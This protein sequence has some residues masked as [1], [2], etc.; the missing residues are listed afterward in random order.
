MFGFRAIGKV[1]LCR[2]GKVLLRLFGRAGGGGGGE[3]PGGPSESAGTGLSDGPSPRAAAVPPEEAQQ[4]GDARSNQQPRADSLGSLEEQLRQV[5]APESVARTGNWQHWASSLAERIVE[6][7]TP[8]L[9]CGSPGHLLR[10]W[11]P[12]PMLYAAT[13]ALLLLLGWGTWLL[14]PPGGSAPGPQN[15]VTEELRPQPTGGNANGRGVLAGRKT[16]RSRAETPRWETRQIALPPQQPRVPWAVVVTGLGREEA[17]AQAGP[18]RTTWPLSPRQ[19]AIVRLRPWTSTRAWWQAKRHWPPGEQTAPLDFLTATIARPAAGLGSA[20]VPWE[21]A[22]WHNRPR[23]WAEVAPDPLDPQTRWLLVLVQAPAPA[24]Q[25]DRAQDLI[26]VVAPSDQFRNSYGFFALGEELTHLAS[27]LRPADRL[28]VLGNGG[29]LHFR[30]QGRPDRDALE[31]TWQRVQSQ[32]PAQLRQSL[33][34]AASVAHRWTRADVEARRH[35]NL[36]V[37]TDLPWWTATAPEALRWARHWGQAIRRV[38]S[39]ALL[40]PEGEVVPG[41]GWPLVAGVWR[42]RH[43]RWQ[44][45]EQLR[46]VFWE[47]SGGGFGRPVRM[48]L[49]VGWCGQQV[50]WFRLPS[51]SKQPGGTRQ[52]SA[53]ADLTGT[54]APGGLVA[55]ML[56]FAPRQGG[57]GPLLANPRSQTLVG[58]L[59]VHWQTESQGW[60]RLRQPVG[61]PRSGT[62]QDGSP[63]F[64]AAWLSVYAAGGVRHPQKLRRWPALWKGWF[65]GPDA[66]P[67]LRELVPL[68]ERRTGFN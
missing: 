16:D 20:A 40:R 3:Q 5:P 34:Q 30:L 53:I 8:P 26:V 57:P 28:L 18:A 9:P 49:Q 52:L 31:R 14:W 47:A 61:V 24:P 51:V 4:A 29:R 54:I 37:V 60:R 64:R 45:A 39:V 44:D 21:T 12:R 7:E 59:E 17:S 1:L 36:L 23:L 63:L 42:M 62:R 43:H 10:L 65:P 6:E 38:R 2:T 35:C 66:P 25:D 48:R 32:T 41:D 22:P 56:Q 11:V 33:Q 15:P 27:R 13:G 50:R 19:D 58:W 67:R 55:A 68:V 46:H